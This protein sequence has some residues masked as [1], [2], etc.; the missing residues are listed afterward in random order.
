MDPLLF[1]QLT[2]HFCYYV[3]NFFSFQSET[4]ILRFHPRKF[5]I[6]ILTHNSV[7]TYYENGKMQT[8]LT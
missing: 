8:S 3:A 6:R 7:L 1:Q 4:K 5:F 2:K